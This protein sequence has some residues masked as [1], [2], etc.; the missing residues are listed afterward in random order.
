MSRR[1]SRLRTYHIEVLDN[2]IMM[3]LVAE[4]VGG[5]PSA[6]EAECAANEALISAL[7]G[8]SDIRARALHGDHVAPCGSRSSPLG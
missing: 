8:K 1:T 7:C 4:W 3:V 2:I 5:L 6:R